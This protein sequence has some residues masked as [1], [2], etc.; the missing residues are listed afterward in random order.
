MRTS[1]QAAELRATAAAPALTLR[2]R[3][4]NKLQLG[5]RSEVPGPEHALSQVSAS[6]NALISFRAKVS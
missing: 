2:S 1:L 5:V 4:K 3:C 6:I